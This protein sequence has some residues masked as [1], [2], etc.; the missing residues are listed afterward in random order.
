MPGQFT[1]YNTLAAASG[2]HRLGIEAD[3]IE[4]ALTCEPPA[5]DGRF[6][7]F[8]GADGLTV[9]VDYAHTPDGL[10]KVL[11]TIRSFAEGRVVTV[12]GCGG[13]RDAAKRPPMGRI[14]G[15]YSDRC[16]LTTDNPRW[17]D[18]EHILEEVEEGLVDTGCPY[19][20][21]P[22]RI[23]AIRQAIETAAPQDVILVAGKGHE[24]GQWIRGERRPMDD[25]AE[26]QKALRER[27]RNERIQGEK[28]YGTVT[29]TGNRTG[30]ERTD[31]RESGDDHHE[32]GTR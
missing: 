1:V 30:C 21:E 11:E 3:V 8:R 16:W 14:A 15:T 27:D 28:E 6:Q 12:F 26:V 19:Q 13:D 22:D 2:C 5:I 20:K 24:T 23:R 10:S 18:P 31:P 9:I 29:L 17:E 32:C 4:E 25:R 7:C